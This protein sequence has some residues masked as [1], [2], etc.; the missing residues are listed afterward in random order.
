MIFL[1]Y[2]GTECHVLESRKLDI[3]NQG[4]KKWTFSVLAFWGESPKGDF[5][6]DI[7]DTVFIVQLKLIK[8]S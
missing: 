4:L 7:F 6:I 2:T 1:W 8:Y 5:I 3:S